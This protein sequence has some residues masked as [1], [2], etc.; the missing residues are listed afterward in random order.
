MQH[1]AVL[2]REQRR[3]LREPSG[4]FRGEDPD[5][6]LGLRAAAKLSQRIEHRTVGF[7]ASIPFD[8][9]PMHDAD[10]PLAN[11]D[12]ALEF[13]G[14]CGLADPRLPGD[15][16]NLP[17]ATEGATPCLVQHT[18]SAAAPDQGAWCRSAGYGGARRDG[19]GH[20]GDKTV[21]AL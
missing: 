21:S 8:A 14:Q 18:K 15:Q 5:E 10:G 4:G 19:L 3:Q 17:L 1:F 20:P 12:P 6:R 11:R 7:L 13:L 2:A 16:D 9:L